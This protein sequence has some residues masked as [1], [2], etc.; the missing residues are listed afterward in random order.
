MVRV[1]EQARV[2]AFAIA[3]VLLPKYCF[4]QV[5]R[6]RVVGQEDHSEVAILHNI[7]KFVRTHGDRHI[8]DH[9]DHEQGQG[10]QQHTRLSLVACA[11]KPQAGIQDVD[12]KDHAN[13]AGDLHQRPGGHLLIYDLQAEG[14][15]HLL[16]RRAIRGPGKAAAIKPQHQAADRVVNGKGIADINREL[17]R[18][19][20]DKPDEGYRRKDRRRDLQT[21]PELTIQR[22][23]CTVQTGRSCG[24]K[25][26]KH[27]CDR[28]RQ[29]HFALAKPHPGRGIMGAGTQDRAHEQHRWKRGN[30]HSVPSP[31]EPGLSAAI[32]RSTATSHKKPLCTKNAKMRI[33]HQEQPLCASYSGKRPSE[34]SSSNF[35]VHRERSILQDSVYEA[36]RSAW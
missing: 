31:S 2:A 23:G 29:V 28:K 27:A 36:F 1:L 26:H 8:V 22:G 21:L 34:R 3:A 5:T 33:F 19:Q 13:C 25:R 15:V 7:D 35:V 11:V 10:P 6:E 30:L 32:L 4:H 14:Q 24:V 17:A 18:I 9:P 20:P 16:D 12:Q